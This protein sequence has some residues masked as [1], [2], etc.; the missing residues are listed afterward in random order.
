MSWGLKK[1]Q[2]GY[3]FSKAGISFGSLSRLL[4]WGAGTL[5]FPWGIS[6]TLF[7]LVHVVLE[8]LTQFLAPE[9][10]SDPG[11]AS[12]ICKVATALGLRQLHDSCVARQS[13]W[14]FFLAFLLELLRISLS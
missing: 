6:L 12:K 4:F 2:M 13:H 9:G 10:G 5:I 1:R 11:L 8:G 3:D 7:L 14:T